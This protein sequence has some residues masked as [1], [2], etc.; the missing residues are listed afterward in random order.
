MFHRCLTIEET[1]K[2]YRKLVKFLHPDVGGDSEIM[3]ILQESYEH[4]MAKICLQRDEVKDKPLE[5]K[6]YPGE[7]QEAD[8]P[9]TF[10]KNSKTVFNLFAEIYRYSEHNKKFD[11]SFV[12]SLSSRFIEKDQISAKS[13]NA[14]LKVYYGFHIHEWIKKNPENENESTK[15]SD[16]MPK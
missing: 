4:H 2:F 3:V 12:D 15:F 5:K 11:T 9:M 8:T 6:K 13:Y 1:K 16:F 7:Y 10:Q 14:L